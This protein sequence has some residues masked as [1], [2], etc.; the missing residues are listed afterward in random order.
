MKNSLNKLAGLIDKGNELL[1]TAT[2]EA[3][4]K[5]RKKEQEFLSA[6]KN[7]WSWEWIIE[8]WTSFLKKATAE[9][10]EKWRKKEKE[11]EDAIRKTI[12]K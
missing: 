11:F 3:L 4:E 2:A 10:L 6:V 9:S 12:N 7:A 1:K 8:K 5:W